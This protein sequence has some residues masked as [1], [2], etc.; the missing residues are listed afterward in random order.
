TPD[1][2]P[3]Y[4]RSLLQVLPGELAGVL[5]LELVPQGLR[6]VVVDQDVPVAGCERAE[7]LEDQLVTPFRGLGTDVEDAVFSGHEGS[8]RR[9][10][11]LSREVL[12]EPRE[13][14]HDAVQALGVT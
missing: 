4:L 3:P 7:R 8:F 10:G 14:V 2:D 12:L 6:I 5:G 9:L 11:Q 1:A 13:V